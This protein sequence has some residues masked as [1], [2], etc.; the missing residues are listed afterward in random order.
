MGVEYNEKI[1]GSS[2]LDW[3]VMP[4]VEGK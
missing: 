1:S 3:L 2:P 4:E